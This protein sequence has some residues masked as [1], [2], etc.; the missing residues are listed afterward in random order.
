MDNQ[1]AQLSHSFN[2]SIAPTPALDSGTYSNS[3]RSSVADEQPPKRSTSDSALSQAPQRHSTSYF[4]W[5][6][7]FAYTFNRLEPT[8]RD[9]IALMIPASFVCYKA[10]R[11]G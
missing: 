3:R 4:F 5:H 7:L 8:L 2:I 9:P 1:D 11:N 6:A 10:L